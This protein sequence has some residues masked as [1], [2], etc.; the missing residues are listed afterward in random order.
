MRLGRVAQA[1]AAKPAVAPPRVS[2]L[3]LDLR[4]RVLALRMLEWQQTRRPAVA[5]ASARQLEAAVPDLMVAAPTQLAV[6]R[7]LRALEATPRGHREAR[8]T[9]ALAVAFGGGSSGEPSPPGRASEPERCLDVLN[10]CVAHGWASTSN[11]VFRRMRERG[12]SLGNALTRLLEASAASP[13]ARD[14]LR[15]LAASGIPLTQYHFARLFRG[16]NRHGA[17]LDRI[18]GLWTQMRALGGWPSP[19]ALSDVARAACK[20]EGGWRVARDA[21]GEAAA[22]GVDPPVG[23]WRE[24]LRACSREH[25]TET[26][27]LLLL[28][29]VTPCTAADFSF[30]LLHHAEA[31]RTDPKPGREVGVLN[32]MAEEG[33]QP[34]EST[35]AALVMLRRDDPAAALR[36]LEE[37][38]EAGVMPG[39]TLFTACA[40]AMWGREQVGAR[41]GPNLAT[42][43]LAAL[44]PVPFAPPPSVPTFGPL[45]PA[46]AM[47]PFPAT[48]P[49]THNTTSS[50]RPSSIPT[51]PHAHP[52]RPGGAHQVDH[53]PGWSPAHP[54][55]YPP[56][57]SHRQPDPLASA[58]AGGARAMGQAR[59]CSP[60]P[61]P[62]PNSPNVIPNPG[63]PHV[64]LSPSHI[65]GA[66]PTALIP[67]P[68]STLVAPL[69]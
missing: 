52:P 60:R 17:D 44:R 7:A 64:T 15:W 40:C 11:A 4:E 35:Y 5:S 43:L 12:L 67:L 29:R 47:T 56:P 21:L 16:C 22:G 54:L 14:R 62:R 34:D 58:D 42:P 6:S 19:W 41:G 61:S 48:F 32:R 33:V 24:V 1:C 50:R 39:Y 37:A 3:P 38:R 66:R 59:G 20:C 57:Q 65:G 2:G 51:Y 18:A 23:A 13:G 31:Q 27:V 63:S 69:P 55:P 9:L 49:D 8:E 28:D 10:L 36:T 25:G 26:D 30:L 46:R 53:P 68:L 45:D